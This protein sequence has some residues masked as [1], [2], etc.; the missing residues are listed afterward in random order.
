LAK[1]LERAFERALGADYYRYEETQS[2]VRGKGYRIV[3]KMGLDGWPDAP[4]QEWLLA[5]SLALGP[6]QRAALLGCGCGLAAVVAAE[7]VAPEAVVTLDAHLLA[8]EAARRAA[9]LNGATGLDIR[10]QDDLAALAGGS[11]DVVLIL[12]PKGKDLTQR[13]LAQAHHLLRCGGEVWLAG[14][15]DAGIKGYGEMLGRVFGNLRV[16]DYRRG[17]RVVAAAKTSA[18]LDESFARALPADERQLALTVRGASY[19]VVTRPG[20]FSWQELDEGTA[21]LA[22][23]MQIGAEETV[24]DL[25]C[26]FGLLGLIAARLAS[27]GR[28]YLVDEN[29]AAVR[30]AA[31][32]LALNGMTNASAQVSDVISAVRDVRFDVVVANPPFHSGVGAQFLTAL[33]F[34]AGS[35]EVLR[36]KGRLYL[37]ANRFIKYEPYLMKLFSRLSVIHADN[38]F[39]VLE[40]VK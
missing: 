37:V 1:P 15:N 11:F 2:F 9:A 8:V 18:A 31:A 39:K 28:V 17:Q 13:A 20:V 38:R 24:L 6:G 32:T 35:A 5:E 10:L 7:Q 30:A 36:P 22:E 21:R 34:I 26:G 40:A 29:V 27:R 19:Q 4:E 3:R 25:G 33:A 23:V 12:L 14:A 16:V